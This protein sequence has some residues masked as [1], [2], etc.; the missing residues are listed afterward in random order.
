M[1]KARDPVKDRRD[2]EPRREET[3]QSEIDRALEQSFPASDP[4]PWTLGPPEWTKA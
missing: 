4:P 3:Q 1:K 2:T